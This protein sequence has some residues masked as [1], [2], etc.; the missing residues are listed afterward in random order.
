MYHIIP[1][2][3][4]GQDNNPLE[5]SASVLV[6][7]LHHNDGA[8]EAHRQC[9]TGGDE[10]QVNPPFRAQPAAD[11]VLVE[12]FHASALAGARYLCRRVSKPL[13][14]RIDDEAY[15]YRVT[16]LVRENFPLT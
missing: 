6:S 14:L 3:L 7:E 2:L 13:V 16:H 9:D 1:E 10:N 11:R 15:M 12:L 4:I 8:Q 5:K